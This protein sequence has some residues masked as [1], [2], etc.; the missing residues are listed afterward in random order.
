[1][2]PPI[3][4]CAPDAAWHQYDVWGATDDASL[5]GSEDADSY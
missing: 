5:E 4:T 3:Y 1:M 2:N